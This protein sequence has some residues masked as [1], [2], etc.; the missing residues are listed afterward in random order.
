MPTVVDAATYLSRPTLTPLVAIGSERGAALPA[1]LPVELASGTLRRYA[2]RDLNAPTDGPRW[3]GRLVESP[4]FT[5]RSPG[6]YGGLQTL[7]AV[8]ITLDDADRALTPLFITVECRARPL[9]IA[10]YDVTSDIVWDGFFVGQISARRRARGRI[11]LTA[12]ATDLARFADRVP[13]S[14]IDIARYPTAQDGGTVINL[15]SGIGLHIPCRQVKARISAGDPSEYDYI[16]ATGNL[17]IDA[18]IEGGLPILSPQGILSQPDVQAFVPLYRVYRDERGRYCTAIRFRQRQASGLSGQA[19]LPVVI[20]AQRVYPDM[21]D[22]VLTEFKWRGDF[23]DHATTPA[24]GGTSGGGTGGGGGTGSP[25]TSIT[26]TAVSGC[27]FGATLTPGGGVSYPPFVPSAGDFSYYRHAAANTWYPP[28]PHGLISVGAIT[29]A[30]TGRLFAIPFVNSRAGAV[31]SQLA[32][33]IGTNGSAGARGRLAIYSATSP[34]NLY[35]NA[36]LVDGAIANGGD[37]AIDDAG[38][39][40]FKTLTIDQALA[41]DTLYY[42]CLCFGG[43]TF[44]DMR[45]QQTRQAQPPFLGWPEP[46]SN[47]AQFAVGLF[48]AQTY[49]TY[50]SALPST[51]PAGATVV[52]DSI[53][54][55]HPLI[56]MR[57]AS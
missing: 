21:D 45:R 23:A 53:I 28:S 49:P 39:L 14:T 43:S 26:L 15:G 47:D 36:L 16:G 1:T 46:T 55:Q 42:L 12:T 2:L 20:D 38:T 22:D 13:V 29:N 27:D 10:I 31:I 30:A 8:T 7:E 33:F 51:F 54:T 9:V 56:G 17:G 19:L 50:P 44:P 48:V 52:S 18:V 4:V 24:D 57:F 34:T 5:L 37:F 3:A 41:E 35:P 11:V 40:P 25:E 6:D 32:C